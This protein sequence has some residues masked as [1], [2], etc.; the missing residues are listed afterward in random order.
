MSWRLGSNRQ[1]QV[2]SIKPLVIEV[3]P[4]DYAAENVSLIDYTKNGGWV[5]SLAPV[6]G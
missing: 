3:V 5:F 6:G 4:E 1:L 2:R